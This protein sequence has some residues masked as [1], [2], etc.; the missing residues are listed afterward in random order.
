MASDSLSYYTNLVT[1]PPTR[2]VSLRHTP[3]IS[4]Q[5]E[6]ID[7]QSRD[8]RR[9]FN[10]IIALRNDLFRFVYSIETSAG[11]NVRYLYEMLNGP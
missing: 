11:R 6:K 4:C 5:S 7:R 3:A 9:L 10:R 2:H 1:V 8:P